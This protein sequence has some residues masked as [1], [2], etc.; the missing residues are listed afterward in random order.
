MIYETLTPTLLVRVS[1]TSIKYTAFNFC[2][3]KTDV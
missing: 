3:G 1:L 2:K